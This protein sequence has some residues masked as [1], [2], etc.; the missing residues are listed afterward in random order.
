[1][2]RGAQKKA[3]VGLSH[4]T[5]CQQ[6]GHTACSVGP[7]HYGSAWKL[8]EMMYSA[9]NKH[10]PCRYFSNEKGEDKKWEDCLQRHTHHTVSH[11]A[12]SSNI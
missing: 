8:Q 7:K 12:G 3:V 6:E 5:G 10:C 9:N 1:M 2:G 11:R 4:L